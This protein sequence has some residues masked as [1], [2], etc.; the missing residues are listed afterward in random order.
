MSINISSVNTMGGYT[1]DK[2]LSSG[3]AKEMSTGTEKLTNMNGMV[4]SGLNASASP[5]DEQQRSKNIDS[6][7]QSIQG[8][9]TTIER[10]V[11]EATNHVMYKVKDKETGE[12][13]REIPEEKLLDMAAKF[14][15][16]NGMMIDEKI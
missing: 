15:E 12:V 14:M 5:A 7:K 9:K 13:I 8:P 16:L 4:E 3:Q 6:E 10:S 1:S 11:H 2:Q